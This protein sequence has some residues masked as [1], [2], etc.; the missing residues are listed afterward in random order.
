MSHFRIR[1]KIHVLFSQSVVYGAFLYLYQQRGVGASH[2]QLKPS[3]W[4]SSVAAEEACQGFALVPA[5]LSIKKQLSVS[6]VPIIDY[7]R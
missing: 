5:L 6:G 3:R 1:F 2:L 4:S 7:N